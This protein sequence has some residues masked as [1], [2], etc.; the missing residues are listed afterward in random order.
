LFT[1]IDVNRLILVR[2]GQTD[3]NLQQT[4]QGHVD[5]PLNETGIHQAEAVARF[6]QTHHIHFDLIYSSP[7]IRARHTAEIIAKTVCHDQPIIMD[8]GL[9]E[10]DFGSYDNQKIDEHYFRMIHEQS[11]PNMETN[12]HL[13]QR[14]WSTIE[15][16]SNQHP[17]KTLLCVTH[18]HVIKSILVRL[19]P[20]FNYTSFL[21]N[22][23]I[24]LLEYD[25][26]HFT[27]LA[28]NLDPLAD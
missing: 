16:L 7:L 13:E 10:R 3:S 6:L 1:V 25:A 27:L 21:Y 20:D 12:A 5:N 24:S 17:D 18:S 22:C 28:H 9:I 14:V 15:S 23:G 2:H 26:H 19:L 8:S 11:I 4:V